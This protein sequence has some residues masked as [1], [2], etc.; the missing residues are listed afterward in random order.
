MRIRSESSLVVAFGGS[1][2]GAIC[3]AYRFIP[4]RISKA[5]VDTRY[6]AFLKTSAQPIETQK[7]VLTLAVF[8]GLKIFVAVENRID[9]HCRNDQDQDATIADEDQP[10]CPTHRSASADRHAAPDVPDE[11]GHGGLS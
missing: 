1:R 11:F 3:E 7:A 8:A 10:V 5:S 6:D 2:V 4:G 9:P